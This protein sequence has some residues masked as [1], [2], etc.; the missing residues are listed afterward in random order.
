VVWRSTV[1]VGPGCRWSTRL[2]RWGKY[3]RSGDESRSPDVRLER[4]RVRHR[5]GSARGVRRARV[6]LRHLYCGPD[7]SHRNPPC[8][9]R[10]VSQLDWSRPDSLLPNRRPSSRLVDA[11][12]PRWW[13]GAGVH[14]HLGTNVNAEA[15]AAVSL[16]RDLLGPVWTG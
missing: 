10:V 13:R 1:S 16:P 5:C 12:D 9:R 2:R 4:S 7:C 3:V 15:C 6:V 8:S 11:T 14:S